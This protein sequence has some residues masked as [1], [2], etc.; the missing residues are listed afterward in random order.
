MSDSTARCIR[1]VI[2]AAYC[3]YFEVGGNR[4]QRDAFPE[5]HVPAYEWIEFIYKW[6]DPQVSLFQ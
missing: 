5:T 3:E 6:L 4:I 2:L 1:S